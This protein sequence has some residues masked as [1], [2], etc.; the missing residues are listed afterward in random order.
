MSVRR[1]KGVHV[2]FALILLGVGAGWLVHLSRGGVSL[3][4]ERQETERTNVGTD[5]TGRSESA[6]DKPATPSTKRS[7]ER[8][9][10][11]IVVDCTDI[12]PGYPSQLYVRESRQ[13]TT[14]IHTLPAPDSDRIATT[15]DL[16]E[17]LFLLSL[18]SEFAI[19]ERLVRVTEAGYSLDDGVSVRPFETPLVLRPRRGFALRVLT[20]DEDE[21]PVSGKLNVLTDGAA[22]SVETTGEAMLYSL[23]GGAHVDIQLIPR[24]AD[25]MVSVHK[26]FVPP[27]DY[28]GRSFTIALQVM[29]KI[30]ATVHFHDPDSAVNP[31]ENQII[32]V[33]RPDS[34]HESDASSPQPPESF[35]RL[36]EGA[37]LREG[38]FA[39]PG[40]YELAWVVGGQFGP[41]QRFTRGE[42]SRLERVTLHAPAVSDQIVVQ[43]LDTEGA[44]AAG[45]ELTVRFQGPGHERRTMLTDSQG[46]IVIPGWD[47][48]RF[49]VVVA[50]P[51]GVPSQPV[52]LINP[53]DGARLVLD[54]AGRQERLQL[55]VSA[56]PAG[57]R[58][59][60][61]ARLEVWTHPDATVRD[62]QLAAWLSAQAEKVSGQTD[63]SQV[64]VP[65]RFM[66]A[67][68]ER[69]AD[70]TVSL[71]VDERRIAEWPW[72]DFVAR[73][74]VTPARV[75]AQ[76]SDLWRSGAN[77]RIA[78]A[79]GNVDWLISH[80]RA[81]VAWF[82][83]ALNQDMADSRWGDDFGFGLVKVGL[84]T[85]LRRAP[86]G[87]RIYSGI[88]ATGRLALFSAA[89]SGND[90]TLTLIETWEGAEVQIADAPE[91][92]GQAVVTGSFYQVEVADSRWTKYWDN[93]AIGVA[94][95]DL[96]ATVRVPR[97]TPVLIMPLSAGYELM[98]GNASITGFIHRPSSGQTLIVNLSR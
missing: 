68:F 22:R 48:E 3:D 87:C 14:T 94:R 28:L 76:V 16:R 17:G 80:G 6:Q 42:L 61:E 5:R 91:D 62:W 84:A 47:R 46:R 56:G 96:P 93:A 54:F 72:P 60:Y 27:D 41:P 43:V 70:V 83:A 23:P 18:G 12:L 13:D 30:V 58:S 36:S 55:S 51:A 79:A 85:K 59:N 98:H 21:R 88:D 69:P 95:R 66:R 26:V 11:R 90:V 64:A 40:T 8:L 78:G 67:A 63:G 74:A 39:A 37:R 29:R 4:Q 52:E 31:D 73:S 53:D 50:P 38:D 49:V 77:V 92:M 2:L 65:D 71:L 25:T 75:E 7:G 9:V 81:P 89:E 19:S 57:P 82:V 33:L 34:Q 45:V 20:V 97:N 15:I 44:P 10:L 1:L 86:R 35:L 32:R 24:D